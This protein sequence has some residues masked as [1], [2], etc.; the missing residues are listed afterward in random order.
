[1][2]ASL[3]VRQKPVFAVRGSL[4]WYNFLNSPTTWDLDDFKYFFDQISKMKQNFVGFH[5][6]DSEPF[7][8]YAEKG[9]LVYA[10]PLVTSKNYGWG[11]VRGL[12]T[13][14]F[15]FGTGDYFDQEQ[16]G[17]RAITEAKGRDDAIRRAQALLAAGLEYGRRRGVRVCVGFEVSGDPTAPEAQ[18]ALEARLRELVRAYPMLDYVWLWQSEGAAAAGLTCRRWIRRW[19][20]SCGNNASSSSTSRTRGGSPRPFG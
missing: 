11:A 13:A 20:S 3:D 5:T 19:M 6:Y 9:K 16:F 7:A 18:A 2:P 1:M 10:E 17:S 15:G 12:A 8:P 14:E 4:P